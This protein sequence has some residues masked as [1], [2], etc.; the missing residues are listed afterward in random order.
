DWHPPDHMSFH[1]RGGPWPRHCVQHTPGAE[2][3][4]ALEL[5]E[6]VRVINKGMNPERENYSAFHDTDLARQLKELG[7]RSVWVGGLALDVC[8]RATVLD[9]IRQGFAIHLILPA[10]RSISANGGKTALDEMRNAGA[11]IH[12]GEDDA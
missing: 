11:T 5:P 8:V 1:E 12:D 3:H 2:F 9:G 7:V 4:P 10:T 6:S